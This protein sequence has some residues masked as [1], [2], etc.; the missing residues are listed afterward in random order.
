VLAILS[1]QLGYI[2]NQLESKRLGTPA[3]DFFFLL[4]I[5]SFGVRRPT[6]NAGLLRWEDR[7][8]I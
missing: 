8:L 2:W 7:P 1:C 3:R 6:S 5:K 4:S